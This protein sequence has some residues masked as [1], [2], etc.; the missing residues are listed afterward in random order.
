MKAIAKRHYLVRA[1]PI[2]KALVHG[3]HGA[4]ESKCMTLLGTEFSV[5]RGTRSHRV[6]RV[7]ADNIR[8]LY[9]IVDGAYE[10]A[11]KQCEE[12][13][14]RAHTLRR[15]ALGQA[16]TSIINA[17]DAASRELVLGVV[18]TMNR[19]K[20]VP[21]TTTHTVYIHTLASYPAVFLGDRIVRAEDQQFKTAKTT[22]YETPT[23]L[24]QVKQQMRAARKAMMA[25]GVSNEE[26]L[27]FDHEWGWVSYKIRGHRNEQL[28]HSARSS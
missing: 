24:N 26:L 8:A 18:P 22:K 3:L 2:N 20:S 27:R 17:V 9:K 13:V 15:S 19:Y 23:T 16:R 6:Y 28:L 1:I 10:A 11:C 4:V 21:P 14:S 25:R 7:S 12:A 5:G